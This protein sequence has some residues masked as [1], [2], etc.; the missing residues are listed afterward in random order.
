ML[1]LLLYLT[2]EAGV[3]VRRKGVTEYLHISPAVVP[4]DTLHQVGGGVVAEVRGHVANP[5]PTTAAFE[6]GGIRVTVPAQA[7]HLECVG[8]DGV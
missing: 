2:S 6:I 4:R 5:Q 7:G 3:V 1:G 8:G